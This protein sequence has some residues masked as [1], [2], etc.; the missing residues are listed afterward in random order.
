MCSRVPG[1]ELV[2]RQSLEVPALTWGPEG[3]GDTGWSEG[4]VRGVHG[5]WPFCPQGF[6]DG[7]S[8]QGP[9]QGATATAPSRPSPTPWHG[10]FLGLLPLPTM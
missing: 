3:W 9:G 10:R 4:G 8:E 5:I 2:P 1:T 7:G 6:P